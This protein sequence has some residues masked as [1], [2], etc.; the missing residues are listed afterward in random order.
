MSAPLPPFAREF[1]SIGAALNVIIGMYDLEEPQ[2]AT[3]YVE[4]ARALIQQ[5]CN[6]SKIAAD[7]KE[8]LKITLRGLESFVKDPSGPAWYSTT[9]HF[10]QAYVQVFPPKPPQFPGQ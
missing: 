2:N 7:V 8:K 10:Q 1:T 9:W 3:N 6:D 4:K 5:L